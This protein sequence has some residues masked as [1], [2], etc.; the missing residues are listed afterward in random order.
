[1]SVSLWQTEDQ[2]YETDFLIVGAGLVGCTAAYFAAQAGRDVTLT[3]AGDLGLGASSRNAG[4]VITGLDAYYHQAIARYGLATV[5][6]I[7][8]L[9]RHTHAIWREFI[10]AGDVQVDDCG[11]MLL[12]ESEDE[13][14]DLASP[15][16]VPDCQHRC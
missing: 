9:S 14:R 11:S 7:W 6:E 5:R 1:M 8:G 10:Q 4:F 16:H 13:A 2:P 15:K 12:A 3:D